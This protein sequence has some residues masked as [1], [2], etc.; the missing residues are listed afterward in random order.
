VGHLGD[1]ASWYWP[2][3]TCW[4]GVFAPRRLVPGEPER[5]PG[6][7][8]PFATISGTEMSRNTHFRAFPANTQITRRSYDGSR[9][10]DKERPDRG[11]RDPWAV[12]EQRRKG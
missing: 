11:R 6:S 12:R 2:G 4:Y 1:A 5:R 3:R 7:R 10:A 9:K 8:M